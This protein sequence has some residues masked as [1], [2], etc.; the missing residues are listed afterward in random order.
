[1]KNTRHLHAVSAAKPSK[2]SAHLTH[3]IKQ[4]IR[5]W[6]KHEIDILILSSLS[7]GLI[8]F[9]MAMRVLSAA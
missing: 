4:F 6:D 2:V 9:V 1:M 8:L 3:T 7:G 5:W